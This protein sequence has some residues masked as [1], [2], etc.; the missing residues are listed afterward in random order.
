[1]ETLKQAANKLNWQMNN[2]SEPYISLNEFYMEIGL[3]PVD[4]G[5]SLGWRSDRGLIDLEFSSKLKDGRTPCLVMSH[6]NPPEY[7]FDMG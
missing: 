5:D 2:L 4:V 6:K 1:M 7:G 3:G